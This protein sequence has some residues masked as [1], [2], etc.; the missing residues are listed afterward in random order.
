[1]TIQLLIA[2]PASLKTETCLESI[3]KTLSKNPFAL[4]WILVP[5]RVQAD[6]MRS[7][8]VQMGGV[9][10]VQIGT[11]SD[12]CQEIYSLPNIY[13]FESKI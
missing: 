12:L 6:E 10:P 3:K 2:P 7:R 1:M 9:F 11:F 5:D 4:V 8:L 13:C